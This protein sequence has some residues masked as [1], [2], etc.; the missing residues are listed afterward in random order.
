VFHPHKIAVIAN[1]HS[2]NRRTARVWPTIDQTLR[3]TLGA[4]T[5][6]QTQHPG[7]ATEL[8]RQALH[9][10]YD[11]IVSAGGD[12]TNHEVINGFFENDAPINPEAALA[13]LPLGTGSD[14]ARTLRIPR[15][16]RAIVY[17][18]NDHVL[19]ADVGR[20][21]FMGMDGKKQSLYFANTCHVGMGGAVAE[22]VA[23]RTKMFGGFITYLS[24]VLST[25]AT[26]RNSYLDFDIDGLTFRQKCRDVVIANG[27]FDG[28]GIHIAPNA[29]LDNGF[30]DAYVMGDMSVAFSVRHIDAFYTGRIMDFADKVSY[31]RAKRITVSSEK[32]IL[33]NLDGELAG[34]LPATFEVIPGALNV[35][36]PR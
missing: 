35:V 17:I 20:A 34:Q 24:A 1:P 30:F 7:H 29:R 26:Y 19:Q 11:R 36:M 32:R 8:V 12:G 25:L 15:G 2:G 33:V 31:F 5:L 3:D 4:Y 21:T 6:L 28:G 9:D 13:L 27:E 16:E 14:L 10:G 18:V 22:T 23:N